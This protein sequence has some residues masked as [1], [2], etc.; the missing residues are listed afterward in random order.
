MMV[1]GYPPPE[2]IGY[3]PPSYY[4][5]PIHGARPQTYP[6]ATGDNTPEYGSGDSAANHETEVWSGDNGTQLCTPVTVDS[7]KENRYADDEGFADDADK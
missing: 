2:Y 5:N 3:M 4:P 1:P 7:D 6:R